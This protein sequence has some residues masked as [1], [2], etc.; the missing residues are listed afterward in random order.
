MR[1]RRNRIF[2]SLTSFFHKAVDGAVVGQLLQHATRWGFSR[3]WGTCAD[4]VPPTIEG[5]PSPLKADLIMRK[6]PHN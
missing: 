6:L 4:G 1:Q 3:G 5:R 2:Q